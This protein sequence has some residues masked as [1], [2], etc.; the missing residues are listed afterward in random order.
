M[1]LNLINHKMPVY[2][3][4]TLTELLLVS[5]SYLILGGTFLSLLSWLL[6]G[7]ASIGSALVLLTLVHVTRFLLSRLQR[8]K[9][10]KPY[11]YYQQLF[12]KQRWVTAI[13]KSRLMTRTGRWS[14]RRM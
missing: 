2:K 9:Y 1:L 5:G 10:G 3:D 11:G 14:I 13:W 7:Y 4:C 6:L 12:L 8:L